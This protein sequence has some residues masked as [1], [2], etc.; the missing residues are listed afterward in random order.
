MRPN[1]TSSSL[2]TLRHRLAP[3]SLLHQHLAVF[4]REP[5][6]SALELRETLRFRRVECALALV[7]NHSVRNA[8]QL[9]YL[10]I[11]HL[12]TLADAIS[13]HLLLLLSGELASMEVC[14]DDPRFGFRNRS[15]PL[16][17]VINPKLVTAGLASSVPVPAIE[18]HSLIETYWLK[19]ALRSDVTL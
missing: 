12:R 16:H 15:L 5:F 8:Q 3:L 19:D 18:Y 7:S 10:A 11:G 2:F 4:V 14:G 1:L 9:C 6:P 13:H 17:Q